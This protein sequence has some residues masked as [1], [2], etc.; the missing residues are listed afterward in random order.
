[1]R[2]EDQEKAEAK[3]GSKGKPKGDQGQR[4]GAPPWRQWN[5]KGKGGAKGQARGKGKDQGKGKR[6]NK[7]R[8]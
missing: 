5:P 3:A 1:M 4:R 8:K 7:N 6:P 2:F